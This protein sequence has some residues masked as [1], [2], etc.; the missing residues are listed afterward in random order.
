MSKIKTTISMV[1]KSFWNSDIKEI[2]S[3]QMSMDKIA[4]YLNEEQLNELEKIMDWV[5]EEKICEHDYDNRGD[6]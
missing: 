4:K 5:A 6:R 1:E 2:S 3:M